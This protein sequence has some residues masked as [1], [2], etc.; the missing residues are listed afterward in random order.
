[1]DQLMQHQKKT[2]AILLAGGSGTRFGSRTNKVYVHAGEKPIFQYGLEVFA[3]HPAVDEI[4]LVVKAGEEEQIKHL[5]SSCMNVSLSDSEKPRKSEN[6]SK[7]L[8]GSERTRESICGKPCK[9]VTGG[10]TRQESV[11][12]GLKATDADI[13]L[14][15]DGAR[16]LVQASYIDGC[17]AAMDTCHG[18]TMA[19]RSKDTIKLADENNMVITTTKRA[20]TWLIQTPQCFHREILLAAH[21]REMGNPEITDDCM[22]LELAGEP[23]KLVEGDYTNIKVT[24]AEDL[25]LVEKFLGIG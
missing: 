7:S 16:P 14:I 19:V 23:V 24:T 17:L 13:V 9:I 12:H 1:M 6:D 18:A 15:H 22:L 5:L 20:N 25:A 10:A 21:E 2:A 3:E 11:Y 4:V 8:S